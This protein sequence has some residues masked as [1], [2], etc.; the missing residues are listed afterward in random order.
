MNLSRLLRATALTAPALAV[1]A[2]PAFAAAPA[3]SQPGLDKIQHIVVIYL[4]N[5]SFDN[6]FGHFPGTDNLDSPGAAITQIDKDGKPYATLPPVW[7]TDKKPAIADERFPQDLP[8]K[9]FQIDSW[10]RPTDKTPD[11]V[12]RYYQNQ[13]QINGGKS[14]QYVAY[15]DAGALVMGYYDTSHSAVYRY[16]KEFTLADHF[17]Q[18]AF[19]GSFINHFWL[20]CACTPTFPNAPDAVKAQLDGDKLVKDGFVTPDGFAVNTAQATYLPHDPTTP[21]AKLLPPQTLP[22]IGDRLDE[23][24]ISWAWYSGGFNAALAGKPVNDFQYH[25]QPFVYFANLADGSKAKAEHLKDEEDMFAALA[26]N[27]LPSVVFYKPVGDENEHPGYANLTDGDQKVE[28]VIQA[29]RNSAVWKNTAIVITYDEFGGFFDHVAPPKVDRWGPGTRVPAIVIS[30][31]AKKGFV[32][33]TVYDTTSIL[34]LIETRYKLKP[35]TDR[36]AKA[37]DLTNAF[38]FNQK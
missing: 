1:L 28:Q 14:D 5:H 36:D 33:H 34:K 30:P 37:N 15:S 7:Q 20:V 11:L 29:I 25:H 26:H 17:F 12:H 13:K 8:N 35:L 24:H 18:G 4:E 23:K 6:M 22:H 10:I 31:Y 27:K 16:A 21:A 38:D 19:G 3:K 32:D 2:S 9:P